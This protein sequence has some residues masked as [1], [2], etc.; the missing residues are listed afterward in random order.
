MKLINVMKNLKVLELFSGIRATSK[1]LKNLGFNVKTTT[2]EFDPQVQKVANKLWDTS[3]PE[4]DVTKFDMNTGD[5]D[6]LVA[7]FPCQ[8]FS[9]M[10]LN[11]GVDD[12]RGGLYLNTLKIIRENQPKF[13]ILENVTSIMNE[14]HVHVVESIIKQLEEDGYSVK[15]QR[16]NSKFFVPQNRPRVF[17]YASKK[18]EL[19]YV[20]IP[21]QNTKLKN[22]LEKKVDERY[23]Y[24]TDRITKNGTKKWLNKN[25]YIGPES[26]NFPGETDGFRRFYKDTH[27]HKGALLASGSGTAVV[28]KWKKEYEEYGHEEIQK[29]FDD[30]KIFLRNLSPREAMRMQGWED[31]DIDK[32]INE[33]TPIE[34]LHVAGNSMTIPVMEAIIKK[35][36]K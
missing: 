10:G 31:F 18:G 13:V 34:V 5:Y 23:Y 14:K 8:P 35:L 6:L 11:L 28:T 1:A 29:L 24:S 3:D 21:E 25:G 2:V 27:T 17:I 9:R 16:I 32:I 20:E 33:F 30:G 4:R 15:V 12:K 7:G 19:D 22:L 26:V 36:I